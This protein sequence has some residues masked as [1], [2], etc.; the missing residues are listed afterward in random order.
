ML[1]TWDEGSSPEKKWAWRSVSFAHWEL[2]TLILILAL[3]LL[4][5]LLGIQYG[6]PYVYFT[7][8]ALLVN[9]AVAFSTG[10]LNPHF[11][12]YP[13]LYMYVLFVIYGFTYV[14]GWLTGVFT[15]TNDFARLFFNDVTL[16]YLP[17]RLIA[18]LSGVTAVATVYLLGRRAYNARVGLIAGA[19]LTFSVLHVTFSHYVKTQV[20]AGL[21]VIITLGLAWSIYVAEGNWH[22]YLLAGVVAGLAASTIYQAGFVLVSVIVAHILRW[23]DSSRHMS[24]V[25]LWSSKLVGA[26]IASFVAFG[27]TTPFAILDWRTFI[28]DL[29]G[30]A[31]LYYY[32]G[33]WE[34]GI[35][36]P[37]TSLFATMGFPLG[38][39]ALLG[40]AYA[41]IRH[42]SA[43]LILLSQPLFLAAFLMLF[44]IKEP[45]HM[46]IAFPALSLLSAS[47]LFDVI[48]WS[49]RPRVLQSLALV[50]VTF[51]VLIG[52]AKASYEISQSMALPDTRKLAKEWVET[53]VPPG[54]RIVMDSGKYYLSTMGPPLRLSKWTIDQF[55]ARAEGGDQHSLAHR[56][57]SRRAGYAREAEYFR[58]QLLTTDDRPGYDIV[59]ILH[60]PGS[61]RADVLT[62]AE[63]QSMGV[64]Y[65]VVNG[66]AWAEYASGGE[67]ATRWPDK[68]QKYRNFYESLRTRATLLHE[69]SPSSTMAGPILRVYRLPAQ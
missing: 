64:K 54:S 11:F 18:A 36:Y 45:H 66:G 2:G 23:R 17:G 29:R 22:R 5:R 63:Y 40:I 12:G 51:F 28:G 27:L 55:V 34:R 69:F 3:V 61:P 1:K 6:L 68:A 25:R 24:E 19:F 4:I 14:V 35:L 49:I 15:S 8:E 30:Y 65:A 62:L 21:L 37:L 48:T 67:M 47:F 33:L 20:P 10:D 44:T 58:Q 9:H 41:L 42:R 43:D 56:D 16:F 39:L 60:D 57:G 38:L 13:S 52:P 32:G 50:I 26:V 31:G 59:Q 46:L 53:N 7:D